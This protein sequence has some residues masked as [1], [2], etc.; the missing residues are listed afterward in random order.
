MVEAHIEHSDASLIHSDHYD[1]DEELNIMNIY[2]GEQL[3]IG[4]SFLQIQQG[5]SHFVTFKRSLYNKTNGINP[6]MKRAVDMDLYNTLDEVGNFVYI[7]KALY[8]Y[9]KNTG[10][11][12]SL[13]EI[14]SI[15][16][17]CWD[18]LSMINACMRRDLSIDE[19]AFENHIKGIE[20]IAQQAA[21]E[22]ELEIRNSKAYRL[23]NALLKPLNFLKKFLW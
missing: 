15:K 17:L 9:R 12:I 18:L 4:M 2:H 6:I 3:P 16:A 8:Y 21:Y 19:I 1:C 22:K 7:N 13:G 10:N 11:N 14:N 23:G 20:V 5:V